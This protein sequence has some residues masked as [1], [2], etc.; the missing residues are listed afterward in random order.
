MAQIERRRVMHRTGGRELV[1]QSEKALADINSVIAKFI[2]TGSTVTPGVHAKY[3][4]FSGVTDFHE[5]LNRVI[6]AQEWFSHLPGAVKRACDQDV[7]KF[8]EKV[9]DPDGRAELVKLGLVDEQ[10]PADAP[11]PTPVPPK[12][13]P[14]GGTPAVPEEPPA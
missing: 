3:G 10:A 5:S 7:G 2:R 4:D 11:D 12:V 13:V 1:K 9:Y 14:E 6:E 8:L